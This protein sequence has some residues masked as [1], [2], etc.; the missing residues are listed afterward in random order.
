MWTDPV[1]AIKRSKRSFKLNFTGP[2]TVKR[3][4]GLFLHASTRFE[5]RRP[6]LRIAR[7]HNHGLSAANGDNESLAKAAFR[8]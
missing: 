3:F 2:R 1:F 7:L 5:I 4:G 6:H 8:I